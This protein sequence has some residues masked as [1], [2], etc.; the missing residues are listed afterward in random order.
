MKIIDKNKLIE[1][2]Y[3]GVR[4]VA[5]K[6]AF[7]KEQAEDFLQE[8]MVGALEAIDHYSDKTEDELV[9]LAARSAYNR[10]V[11]ARGKDIRYGRVFPAHLD[12]VPE[13]SSH[14]ES[15]YED[16]QFLAVLHSRLSKMGRNVLKEK[17]SPGHR[18]LD[19]V[20]ADQRRKKRDHDAG[21]LVMNMNSDRVNDSHI[22][23][24]LKVSKATLSREISKL[25][26]AVQDMLEE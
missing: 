14:S 7:N 20:E 21:K 12:D 6:S 16:R 24:G 15:V 3:A 11:S 8:G 18:T 22:A 26:A 4:G 19:A 13:P 23:A 5:Y 25:R 10:I 2:I 9:L 17:L 1:R